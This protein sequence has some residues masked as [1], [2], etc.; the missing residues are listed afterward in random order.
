MFNR[1]KVDFDTDTG[2]GSMI[3]GTLLFLITP[4]MILGATS[5]AKSISG[6]PE[7]MLKWWVF[8]LLSVLSVLTGGI[9]FYIMVTEEDVA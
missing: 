8:P 7:G 2:I 9:I 4:F 3:F 1:R 6:F 5:I